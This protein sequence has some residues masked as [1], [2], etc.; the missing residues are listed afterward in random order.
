MKHFNSQRN[1]HMDSMVNF[2][3]TIIDAF[4]VW[5]NYSRDKN[6]A[7]ELV[8]VIRIY[9]MLNC[10]CVCVRSHEFSV[11]VPYYVRFVII[12]LYVFCHHKCIDRTLDFKSKW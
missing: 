2:D 12:T 5:Y 8:A 9:K 7:V 10:V 3:N 1:V 11:S 6:K 4:L